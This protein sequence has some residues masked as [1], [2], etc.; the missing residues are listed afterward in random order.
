MIDEILK[1]YIV[2]TTGD[3][4]SRRTGKKMIGKID[5]YGYR[6]LCLSLDC[7]VKHICEHRIEA[8]CYLNNPDNCPQVN[9]KDCNKLNNHVSNLEWCTAKENVD[10]AYANG[11]I[12]AWNKGR[13]GVYSAECIAEMKYNQPNKKRV[14]L[15][16]KKGEV[17]GKYDSL[18]ALCEQMGFDRRTAQRVLMGVPNYNS[19]KGFKISLQ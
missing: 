6:T 14:L 3:V 12:K 18:S 15:T 11:L 16:D 13:T 4:V 19:I 17:I 10:H 7:G 8:M 2:L 1:Y 5:K 9:H